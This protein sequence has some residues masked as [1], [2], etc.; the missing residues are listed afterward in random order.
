MRAAAK[1][2]IT[3]CEAAALAALVEGH[4]K[5]LETA[6]LAERVAK[7]EEFKGI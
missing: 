6:D 2:R 5:A 7:L 3:P 4:R 1:G